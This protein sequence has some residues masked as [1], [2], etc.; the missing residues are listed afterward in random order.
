MLRINVGCGQTPTIG[1]SNFD[2]S[3]SVRLARGPVARLLP[4]RADY[5]KAVREYDIRYAEARRLP[6]PSA[7]ADV[8][9]SSHMLEH[10]DREEA[11]LFLAEAY[12]VLAPGGR[13]R[14][15][16]PDLAKMAAKY[17]RSGDADS[18]IADL[19]MSQS[20]P[21]RLGRRLVQLVT[22]FREH[23][24]MY[25]GASLAKLVAAAG[26]VDVGEKQP[27]ETGIADPG[28]LDLAERADQSVFIEA[29]R[30]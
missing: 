9:Y 4:G 26:F 27:G 14:L 10:L 21:P 30:P 12:R 28:P 18:F 11:S 17:A 16:V 19:Q 7:S 29:Q 13:I 5:V 8:I 22:G 20:R 6:V 25:D 23:R 2:N 15:V 3:W 1:W 24:W